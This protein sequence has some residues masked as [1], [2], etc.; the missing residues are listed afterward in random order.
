M[1]TFDE[2]HA[3]SYLD[4]D[5]N[6]LIQVVKAMK[7]VLRE[8]HDVVK[9]ALE[10]DNFVRM[11][12]CTHSHLPTLKI[13]GLSAAADVF[14]MFESAVSRQDM[15]AIMELK[16]AV[17]KHWQDVQQVLSDWLSV[18]SQSELKIPV[19]QNESLA[20]VPASP[21]FFPVDGP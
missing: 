21:H 18:Q 14:E 12:Q 6:F 13:L 10:N 11:R 4:N 19:Q 1:N 7:D 17:I 5:R 16:H 3:L 15:C 20:F 8:Q 2:N 9:H